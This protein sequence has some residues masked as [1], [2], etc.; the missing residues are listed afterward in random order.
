[1][2]PEFYNRDAQG[3]PRAG[4][5]RMRESMA[6]LTPRFSANRALCEYAEKHYIQAAAP[7]GVRAADKG[8][9]GKQMVDWQQGLADRWATLRLGEVSVRTDRENHEFE[10]AFHAGEVDPNSVRV[11]LYAEGVSGGP[12]VGQEMNRGRQLERGGCVYAAQVPA[13]RSSTDY[14]VRVMPRFPDA[15]VPL[16]ATQILWRHQ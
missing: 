15:A 6:R 11:E 3:T 13:T 9:V 5:T 4:V 16:E 2:I 10:V 7:Y 12:P 1:M 8:A 14:T